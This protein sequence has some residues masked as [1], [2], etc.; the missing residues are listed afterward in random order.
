M[1]RVPADERAA[2]PVRRRS[3]T[4]LERVNSAMGARAQRR[5]ARPGRVGP[6]LRSWALG[7]VRGGG[8]DRQVPQMSGSATS[9]ASS[10]LPTDPAARG[11]GSAA[12]RRRRA[13]CQGR[14][15]L[16]VGLDGPAVT[17]VSGRPGPGCRHSVGRRA[18]DRCPR[19]AVI[20]CGRRGSVARP[21]QV[22]TG[23]CWSVPWLSSERTSRPSRCVRAIEGTPVEGTN[24]TLSSCRPAGP[25]GAATRSDGIVAGPGVS[26]AGRSR[27]LSTR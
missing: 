18:R 2:R 25:P 13:H 4:G 8:Q 11:G 24:R 7:R 23:T 5:V 15:P 21:G 14:H 9:G 20:V 1:T 10:A 26:P 19:A 17:A 3:G 27:S 6:P 16:A 12:G 22:P